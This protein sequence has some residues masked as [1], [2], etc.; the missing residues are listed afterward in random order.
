VPVDP[1][2]DEP[3]E[4]HAE[5]VFCRLENRSE[6]S[7]GFPLFVGQRAASIQFRTTAYLGLYMAIVDGVSRL[8]EAKDLDRV[9]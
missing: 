2:I 6:S 7:N 9:L 8:I 3:V 4:G 1:Y 5:A